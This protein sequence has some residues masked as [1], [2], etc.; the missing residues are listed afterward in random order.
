MVL[1][2]VFCLALL[3]WSIEASSSFTVEW[4][5]TKQ[6]IDGFGVSC[7][8]RPAAP[9]TSIL[10]LLF[11]PNIGI[12]LSLLRSRVSYDMP[13]ATT[14]IN[15]ALAAHRYG[16]QVWSTPWS[17]PPQWKSNHNAA[18]GG[19]LLPQYYQQY[20]TYLANYVSNTQKAFNC[21]RC[22][23]TTSQTTLQVTSLA[24]GMPPKC[25]IL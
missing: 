16:V 6:R 24:L 7:A 20:A 4:N 25:M 1:S 10:N 9:P 8:T 19:Y 14:E 5:N 3:C 2:A 12:G 15:F 23:S 18:N 13:N 22:P 11:D 17:P 21:S